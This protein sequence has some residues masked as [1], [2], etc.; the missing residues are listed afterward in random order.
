M[1]TQ[2]DESKRLMRYLRQL[3]NL[4]KK[5]PGAVR[6]ILTMV[7]RYVLDPDKKKRIVRH[8]DLAERML[9]YG[10]Y[11]R[12]IEFADELIQDPIAHSAFMALGREDSGEPREAL[13]R[14]YMQPV[15]KESVNPPI[16]T[17]NDMVRF[18]KNASS[19]IRYFIV[20]E[21]TTGA[22]QGIVSVNDISRHREEITAAD[23]TTSVIKLPFFNTNP[24]VILDSDKMELA[25]NLF[26]ESQ[27][28]GKRITKL[29]VV[30][31]RKRPTGFLAEPDI[32]RW[33]TIFILK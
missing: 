10:V 1:A 20:V 12:V 29:L 24:K 25:A 21:D 30:D 33:E 11:K 2:D 13:V 4:Y 16:S 15:P 22:L 19:E 26:K 7:N 18:F 32:V 5:E 6:S 17:V 14:D 23:K 27:E 8:Q 31:S 3:D 9:D 28:A